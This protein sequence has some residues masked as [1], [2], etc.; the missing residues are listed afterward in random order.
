MSRAG[1]KPRI[2]CAC[3]KVKSRTCFIA[4]A[5]RYVAR[6]SLTTVELSNV[7]NVPDK[8]ATVIHGSGL[9]RWSETGLCTV[10][11]ACRARFIV[12]Y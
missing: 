8:Y 9:L 5:L 3:S 1:N 4:V 10:Y 12:I 7:A 2:Y 6:V 11:T